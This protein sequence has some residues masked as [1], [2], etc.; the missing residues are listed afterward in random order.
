MDV[1]GRYRRFVGYDVSGECPHPETFGA[2]SGDFC[3]I[4]DSVILS[5]RVAGY[6]KLIG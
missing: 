3:A 1:C 6:V 2:I 4:N 5:R